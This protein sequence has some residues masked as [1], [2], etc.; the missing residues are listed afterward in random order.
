MRGKH[1]L[2]IDQYGCRYH[3]STVANLRQQI[4]NGGSKVYKMYKDRKDGKVVHCGYV[5]GNHWLTAYQPV[6]IIVAK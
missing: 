5:I 1:T 2:Y 3:A 4:E 6:E